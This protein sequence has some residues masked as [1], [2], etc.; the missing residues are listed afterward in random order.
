[1]IGEFL[2]Y[3]RALG[4][5]ETWGDYEYAFSLWTDLGEILIG[6]VDPYADIRPGGG[7]DEMDDFDD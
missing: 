1:E 3:D 4:L 2:M 7:I 6:R 5:S